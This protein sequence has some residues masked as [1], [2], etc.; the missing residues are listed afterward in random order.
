M[1]GLCVCNDER[2]QNTFRQPP[3]TN[4]QKV[5]IMIVIVDHF[6]RNLGVTLARTLI[7]K[8]QL[9]KTDAKIKTKTI[10]SKSWPI[11]HGELIHLEP[12]H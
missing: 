6:P 2:L 5:A 4:R 7:Y 9:T 8:E 3:E 11:R 12:L 10:K 1:F